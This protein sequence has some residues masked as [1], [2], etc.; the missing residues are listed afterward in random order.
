MLE[1]N[2]ISKSYGNKVVLNN[3][4]M[5]VNQNEAVGILGTNGS[6]KSTLLS[7]IARYFSNTDVA[8]GYVPQDNPLFDELSAI[9]NIRLWTKLGKKEIMAALTSTNLSFLGISEYVKLPVKKMSGGMKKRVSLATALINN[10]DIL[11]LDEPFAALDLPAKADILDILR[12]YVSQNHT[13]IVASHD[14]D[15]FDF[16]NRVYLLKD[17]ILVDANEI[18]SK[19]QSYVDILRG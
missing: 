7:Y 11:L 16:C 13:I 14:K 19:G 2:N 15:L 4:S 18:I 5:Y 1:L 12:S 3:T 17:Q 10:P 9:D 6:G 8:V